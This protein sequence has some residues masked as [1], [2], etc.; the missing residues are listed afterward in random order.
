VP[1]SG[2]WKSSRQDAEAYEGLPM[3]EASFAS[4][5]FKNY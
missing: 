4:A 5:G 2:V 1:G 3:L